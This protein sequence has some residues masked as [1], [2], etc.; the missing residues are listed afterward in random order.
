MAN[1]FNSVTLVGR[2]TRDAEL[3]AMPGGSWAL[4]YSLA[5]NRQWK[6]KTT[7][8]MREETSF[9]DVSGYGV[10]MDVLAP[11]LVK[12]RR[13]LVNGRLKQETWEKDG[14][15]RTAVKVIH[16]T[17]QFLDHREEQRPAGEATDAG[18]QPVE[19]TI[20]PDDIPF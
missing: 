3:R 14:Q 8:E 19:S 11:S 6:D 12:G 2:L 10:G 9:F 18:E 7:G 20:N 13:V 15:K 1:D 17:M 4:S 16:Q 5:V